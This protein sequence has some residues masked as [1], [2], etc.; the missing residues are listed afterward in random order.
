MGLHVNADRRGMSVMKSAHRA[1]AR[2]NYI[3]R[4]VAALLSFGIIGEQ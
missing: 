3:R 1:W 4:Y 2:Q